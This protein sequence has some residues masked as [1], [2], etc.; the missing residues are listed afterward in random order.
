MCFKST[1]IIL[2]FI[3]TKVEQYGSKMADL[4]ITLY[5]LGQ[6][7]YFNET[8]YVWEWQPAFIK[9]IP[10][11][12]L[13][14]FFGECGPGSVFHKGIHKDPAKGLGLYFSFGIIWEFHSCL[15]FLYSRNKN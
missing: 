12:S 1:G 10:G 15:S 8:G 7:F 9:P 2:L 11:C 6:L 13:K 14:N 3:L 5:R 4:F